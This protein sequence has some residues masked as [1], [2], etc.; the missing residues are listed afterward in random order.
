MLYT[1]YESTDAANVWWLDVTTGATGRV[2]N[3]GASVSVD[4]RKRAD[5]GPGP[6]PGAGPDPET[7]AGASVCRGNAGSGTRRLLPRGRHER[8]PDDA[9]HDTRRA[10]A[11]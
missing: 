3:D 6:E 10:G 4:W 8:R 1:L 7:G 5:D 9:G 11:C 2:T